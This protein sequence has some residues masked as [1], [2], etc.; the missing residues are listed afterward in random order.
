[1]DRDKLTADAMVFQ[2]TAE[3]ENQT[4]ATALRHWLNDRSW[5]QI[6]KLIASR[7]VLVSGNLCVDAGRKLKSTDVVKL[8]PHSALAPPTDDDVKVEYLDAHVIV[9]EKPT[10]LTSNRH[11]EELAWSKRRKQ[12]QPTLDELLPH[13]ICK[14]EGRRA[15]RGVPPPVRAVHR[16]DRDTSGLMVFAR[17]RSAEQHLA[18]QFRQHSTHRRYLAIVEG[19]VPAQ[20]IRSRLVRDRGDGRRGSSILPTGGKEATTHITPISTTGNYSLVQCRLETGRTHQ[21]RIH[22]SEHGHPVCGDKVYRHPKF[23]SSKL[24]SSGAP[25]MALHAAELG[26]M[27]PVSAKQLRFQSALPRELAEFWQRLQHEASNARR[28]QKRRTG[29]KPGSAPP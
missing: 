5:T 20:T 18:E 27:H 9:V 7:H 23:G 2:L 14:I 24:D 16:L 6:R 12:I 8:L 25:R 15:Q 19:Q 17:T 22:L 10:G 1:M 26:F 29:N 28:T 13:I 11:R 21:I 4:I 3:L